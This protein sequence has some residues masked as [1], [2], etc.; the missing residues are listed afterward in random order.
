MTSKY[1]LLMKSEDGRIIRHDTWGIINESGQEEADAGA[2]EC[3]GKR[4][5]DE[6]R[7]IRRATKAA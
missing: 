3:F 4:L 5:I 1:W 6:A 7:A 2:M